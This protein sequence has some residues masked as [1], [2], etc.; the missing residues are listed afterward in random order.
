MPPESFSL[1]RDLD[2]LPAVALEGAV[3]RRRAGKH[4]ERRGVDG[5]VVARG[6]PRGERDLADH[7]PRAVGGDLDDV[8]VGVRGA[9]RDRAEQLAHVEAA[10]L[11]EADAG[12]VAEAGRVDRR[13][14]ARDDA[15]HL[16]AVGGHAVAAQRA[17]VQRAVRADAQRG[18]HGLRLAE[19]RDDRHER[20]LG[21][22][23]LEDGVAAGVRDVLRPVAGDGDAVRVRVDV[24]LVR[25]RL[26]L[27]RVETRAGRDALAVGAPDDVGQLP[28]GLRREALGLGRG[29][30]LDA[31]H[32]AVGRERDVVDAGRE[33]AVRACAGQQAAGH[34]GQRRAVRGDLRDLRG[35]AE[36]RVFVEAR[37]AGL[38]GLGHVEG[39]VGAESEPARVVEALGQDLGPGVRG[40]GGGAEGEARQGG[41]R[42]GGAEL[43]EE[44]PSV[45]GR[46]GGRGAGYAPSFVTMKNAATSTRN[47]EKYPTLRTWAKIRSYSAG[48]T[49]SPA[50]VAGLVLAE[51]VA[52]R[53]AGLAERGPVAQGVVQDGQQVVAPLRRVADLLQTLV[54]ELL[55]ALGLE[56]LQALDLRVLGGRVDAQG[57]G[58]LRV[59]LDVVVDAD[60][61]VL[62]LLVAL[63]I[64]PGR[65]LDLVLDE[66]DRVHAAAE[67]VD[68][69]DQLARARLDLVGERLDEVRAGE[70]VHGVGRA[71]LVS[72]D[73]LRAQRDL[74]GPLGGQRERLVV[75]VGVQ[76]LRAAA[77]R[78]EALQRDADDVVL[79]LLRG[80]RH[81]AG[82]R[83]EAQH[84]RLRVGGPEAVAHDVGPH[85]AG[86]AELRDLLEDVVVAVEEEGQARGEVVDREPRVERRLHVGDAVGQREA[87]LLHGA[88]A[89][90]AEVVAADADRVPLRH[91]L[92]AVREEVGRQPHRALGRVDEVPAGD[93][94]LEDVVLRRAPQ[95]L[96]L[97]ALLLADDLV[98]AQQHAGRRVDRHRRRDLVE[99]DL[100]E[101]RAHVVDRVDGDPGAP[102][103]AQAARVVGVQAELG[104]Q[105]EGHRQ[106]RRA[107][108][109]EVAVALV[110]LL[111]R[112]VARVLAHRPQLLA[113][114][115]AVHAAGVGKVA[116]LAELQLVRNVVGRVEGLDLDAGVGEASRVVGA[117]DGRD[118]QTLLRRSRRHASKRT[119]GDAAVRRPPDGRAGGG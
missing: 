118:R 80:E 105:V 86:G 63:G 13:L 22:G 55:V 110:G 79:G 90:L 85:L 98:E 23:D 50:S 65:L 95:L 81:A 19:L 15:E 16:R 73:L 12:D 99:R 84:R 117:H 37:L 46:G 2:D 11:V 87:D 57:L 48:R 115:L 67:L 34:D 77:D 9:L 100:V 75:A 78:G 54:D 61:D 25:V 32:G 104:R 36:A 66:V 58:D 106:A 21:R 17:D 8:A 59:L 49:R 68:L 83:V 119:T 31:E 6:D 7:G 38:A 113:V 40:D 93:V 27:D 96:G 5:A 44:T 111:G 43:Q 114:H 94:L 20:H 103:L 10:A 76:R 35:V 14:L 18:R 41:G 101:R 28:A 53:A 97:D 62:A 72:D 52:H 102:D 33:R 60:H 92:L 116:G 70:R 26:Q 107:V 39:A 1:R 42:E 4:R 24:R 112:R 89:L 69:G 45:G 47:N 29:R 30:R 82:L 74:R 91:A 64:A 51:D 56:R 3:L 109:D 108:L 88:A 71:G